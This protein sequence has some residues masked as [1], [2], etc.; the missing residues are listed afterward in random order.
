M[1]AHL[2]ESIYRAGAGLAPWTAALDAIAKAYDLWVVHLFA[3]DKRLGRV[4]FS[5]EG[6]SSPPEAALDWLRKYR[7]IDPREALLPPK[8]THE[9]I[10][11][12]EHF[13]ERFVAKD[14]FYQNFLIPYGG[15][16]VYAAKLID[17]DRNLVVMG[18]HRGSRRGQLNAS[19]RR[20]V[21]LLAWHIERAFVMQQ[22]VARENEGRSLGL[23]I[24]AR[25][26]QPL[27]LVDAQRRIVFSNDSGKAL[28]D[29]GDLLSE[30]GGYVVCGDPASDLELT[31]AL[32]E[33]SLASPASSGAR[34]IDRRG[35]R[36]KRPRSKV[37]VA[38]TLLALRPENVLA[39]FG[40]SPLAM[41]AIY[42]PGME[43]AL[44]P[45]LLATTFDLT[46]AEARVAAR[47]VS[48]LSIKAIASQLDVS[49]STVRTQTKSILEKTGTHRQAEL[50][51]VLLLAGEF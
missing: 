6:G 36:L 25:M 7:A 41:L 22:E 40:H 49:L 28:L 45:F 38:A 20:D 21:E 2:I 46:P 43:K 16:Y 35:L 4:M 18:F 11:C 34:L 10:A 47:L 44:D 24:L 51:R 26:R 39:A 19:E 15:R 12:D 8:R 31:L 27:I 50:V 23:A 9:W 14:P 17:D 1:S 29:R 30:H 32:R 33:L 5:H 42:E 48:G 37:R 13:D 3:A